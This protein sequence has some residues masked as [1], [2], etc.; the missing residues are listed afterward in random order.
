MAGPGAVVARVSRR[1]YGVAT[2]LAVA[3]AAAVLASGLVRL[4]MADGGPP[5]APDPSLLERAFDDPTL[6]LLR[7]VLLF[8]TAFA[9]GAVVQRVLLGSYAVKIGIKEGSVEIADV[10]VGD[11]DELHALETLKDGL[12]DALAKLEDRLAALEAGRAA[13]PGA[14]PAPVRD[15]PPAP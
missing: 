12:T 2:G 14:G 3:A 7:L 1:H 4:V 10:A 8:V 13:G 11:D 9:V 15:P 6:D 5:P